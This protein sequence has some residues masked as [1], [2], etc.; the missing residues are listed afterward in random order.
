[1]IT[2]ALRIVK[3]GRW[4]VRLNDKDKGF[5]LVPKSDLADAFDSLTEKRWYE[6]IDPELSQVQAGSAAFDIKKTVLDASAILAQHGIA[7]QEWV[8][9]LLSGF[10]WSPQGTV[11]RL[12][13]T[14]K[15]HRPYGQVAL[16]PLHASCHHPCSSIM[17]FIAEES[18]EIL[19]GAHW[20]LRD[21]D[22][23]LHKLFFV[24]SSARV[25][26]HAD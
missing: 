19:R 1:M 10:A 9:T 4:G 11:A 20:L 6:R 8:N 13:C 16:R 7:E 22:D 15:S 12:D 2:T 26:H 14:V 23:L 18:R 17:K 21:T 24:G 5:Y 3:F 25:P